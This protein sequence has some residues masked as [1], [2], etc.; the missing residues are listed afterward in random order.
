MK[1]KS[2]SLL[3]LAIVFASAS[4]FAQGFHAG[5]KGGVNLL[6][7]DGKSFNEEFRHG[8]NAGVSA[9]INFNNKWGIQPEILWNQA[10]TRT[11]SHFSDIYNE[12]LGELKDVKLNYLSVPILLNIKPSKMLTLQVGPQ[13]GV[14]INKDQDLLENGQE[15]FKR[16]DFSMLAGAQI[17]FGGIKVGGRYAVGLYNINDID[18]RDKWKNQGFQLYA[19]FNIF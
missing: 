1:Q 10:N 5:V 4:T 16:G 3:A 14:L 8:Y 6:K 9:E 2:L 11:S 7:V 12:G 19:G 13:F 17:N 18:N 15:A